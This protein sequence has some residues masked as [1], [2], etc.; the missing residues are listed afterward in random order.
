MVGPCCEVYDQYGEEGVKQHEAGGSP[1]G[2]G[3]P[4]GG[5][6]GFGGGGQQFH[7]SFSQ[8]G[9]GGGRGRRDPF[10]MFNSVFGEESGGR[11]QRA[12]I[13]EEDRPKENLFAKD[14]A[15]SN[16]K[17]GKFPD[18]SSKHIWI[19]EFYAPWCGHCRQGRDK[20]APFLLFAHDV[21]VCAYT[22]AASSSLARPPVAASAGC[23][24][25]RL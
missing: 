24:A 23:T 16:L 4:F 11:R 12:N 8:S 2:G 5:G 9:G 14:S 6:G 17:Q 3:H 15:V 25:R 18:T 10:D 20:P 22:I 13:G 21:P 7:F 19:I 1:G